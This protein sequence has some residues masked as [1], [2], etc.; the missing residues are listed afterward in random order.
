[1]RPEVFDFLVR[2]VGPSLQK[3]NVKKGETAIPPAERLS[4]TL[5]FLASG[6]YLE[7]TIKGLTLLLRALRDML[8]VEATSAPFLCIAQ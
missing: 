7:Y 8:E 1:M 2:K 5:R 6:E 4:A 3:D